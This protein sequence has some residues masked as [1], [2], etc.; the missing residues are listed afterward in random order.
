[1]YK[2]YLMALEYF[3]KIPGFPNFLS[4][5]KFFTTKKMNQKIVGNLIMA[6]FG[7]KPI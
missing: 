4:S 1:M 3:L 7:K 6:L 2:Y 5:L